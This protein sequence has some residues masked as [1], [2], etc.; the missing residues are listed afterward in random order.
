MDVND[1]R[2]FAGFLL[3]QFNVR[4]RAVRGQ[5]GKLVSFVGKERL[6][7]GLSFGLVLERDFVLGLRLGL[8]IQQNL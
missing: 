1:Q 6:S 2:V 7:R 3:I 8:L 4:G 5:H